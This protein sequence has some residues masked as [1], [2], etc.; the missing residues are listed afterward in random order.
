MFGLGLALQALQAG[1]AVAEAEH[2]RLAGVAA[3]FAAPAQGSA[4][5]YELIEGRCEAHT[6]SVDGAKRLTI[7]TKVCGFIVLIPIFYFCL[8][9]YRNRFDNNALISGISCA[10]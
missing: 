10:L 9:Q 5:H 7:K 6:L 1:D 8:I 4:A 2:A 3:R